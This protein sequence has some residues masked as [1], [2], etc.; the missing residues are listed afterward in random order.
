M[1]PPT[2]AWVSEQ[3]RQPCTDMPTGQADPDNFPQLRFSSKVILSCVKLIVQSNQ[4]NPREGINHCR[5]RRSMRSSL[6]GVPSLW[7]SLRPHKAQQRENLGMLLWDPQLHPG[8]DL[9]LFSQLLG[10]AKINIYNIPFLVPKL[11]SVYILGTLEMVFSVSTLKPHKAVCSSILM[12]HQQASGVNYLWLK[13]HLF[14]SLC[15]FDTQYFSIRKKRR[16]I[17]LTIMPWFS[18]CHQNEFTSLKFFLTV[19][20]SRTSSVSL[21]SHRVVL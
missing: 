2:V 19:P 20:T 8:T 10:K 9:S 14:L 5:I 18:G 17:Q 3:S 16:R 7:F 4:Y 13:N 15:L 12:C 1:V 11:E 21:F 6:Q